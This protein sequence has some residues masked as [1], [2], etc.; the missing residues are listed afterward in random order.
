M[1]GG[2]EVCVGGVHCPFAQIMKKREDLHLIVS[3]ATVDAEV[4]VWV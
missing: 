2:C 3:S 1:V 4:C